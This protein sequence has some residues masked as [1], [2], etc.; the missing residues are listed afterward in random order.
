[1]DIKGSPHCFSLF[2]THESEVLLPVL[3]NFKRYVRCGMR[4]SKPP[5]NND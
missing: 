5:A 1:M 3:P 2:N 4:S